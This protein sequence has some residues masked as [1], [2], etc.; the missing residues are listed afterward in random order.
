L[1]GKRDGKPFPLLT[2]F[3]STYEYTAQ[4][5]TFQIWEGISSPIHTEFLW[6]AS[7][8]GFGHTQQRCALSLICGNYSGS[9]MVKCCGFPI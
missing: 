1:I 9:G 5:N 3:W 4:L 6:G 2:V 7:G 8:I